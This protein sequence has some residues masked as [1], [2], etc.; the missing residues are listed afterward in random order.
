[1]LI[2]VRDDTCRTPY[3]DAPVKH[4]DHV[5][6]YRE[7]GATSAAN[8]SGLCARCNYTKENPAWT[9]ASDGDRLEVTTPTGHHYTVRTP[10]LVA[11]APPGPPSSQRAVT[12][13]SRP[14]ERPPDLQSNLPSDL[15]PDLPCEIPPERWTGAWPGRSPSSQP[16]PV[17]GTVTYRPVNSLLE[18]G[19]IQLLMAAA[20]ARRAATDSSAATTGPRR[21]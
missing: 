18:Q 12:P 8:A 15:P 10:P 7:G 3:C 21:C 4:V 5:T 20:V 11:G 9:H 13:E 2:L 6:P 1:Q 14:P 19:M 16:D 17:L